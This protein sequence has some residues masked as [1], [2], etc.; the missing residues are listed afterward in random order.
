MSTNRAYQATDLA[1][2]HRQ[3]VDA[4]RDGIAII[5]DKDGTTLVMTAASVLDRAQVIGSTAVALVQVAHALAEPA[6]RRTPSSYGDFAWLGPLR[7]DA[8]RQFLAEMTDRLVVVASGGRLDQLTE[9]IGDWLATA[10]AWAD[11]ETREALLAEERDPMHGV[12][13]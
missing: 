3:V 6:D 11:P 1:R 2:N 5:R 9:L 4:A 7:E 8:Q 10:E 13:L 12:E